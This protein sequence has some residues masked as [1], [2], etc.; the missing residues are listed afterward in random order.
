MKGA[1]MSLLQK[2]E[3]KKQA[4]LPARYAFNYKIIPLFLLLVV[5]H[6]ASSI[7][8][9]WLDGEKY[10]PA[11]L[12]NLGL[13]VI[14]IVIIVVLATK[15]AKKELAVALQDY[16]YLFQET[17]GVTQAEAFDEELGIKFVLKEDGVT[18]AFP[19]KD[20]DIFEELDGDSEFLPWS[21]IRMA[22]ATDNFGRR[23]RFAIV[24]IENA[25][26][27]DEF[28]E[29]YFLTMTKELYEAI[30]GLKLL[31]KISPDFIYLLKNPEKGMKQILDFGYIRK[32]S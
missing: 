21:D 8:L 23:A 2:I 27:V 3:E 10:L 11:V 9:A 4:M 14:E 24:V 6:I 20:E 12:I 29:P 31:E 7:L 22:F 17:D 28:Y 13:L 19:K 32:F 15:L 26:A 25:K 5:A 16:G 1:G 18:V 30:V